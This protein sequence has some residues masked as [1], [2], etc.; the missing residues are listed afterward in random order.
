MYASVFTLSG[1]FTE[2]DEAG[3]SR[4]RGLGSS[5]ALSLGWCPEGSLSICQLA[6]IDQD[7]PG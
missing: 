5:I 2:D 6:A 7:R 1:H 3:A 4:S